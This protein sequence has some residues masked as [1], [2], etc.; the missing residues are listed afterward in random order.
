MIRSKYA[1]T[2][3]A[4]RRPRSMTGSAILVAAESS[5]AHPAGPCSRQVV[6]SIRAGI[7]MMVSELRVSWLPQP[8]LAAEVLQAATR[9]TE[10]QTLTVNRRPCCGSGRCATRRV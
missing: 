1:A 9:A 7:W 8:A 5:R 4:V 3:A 6:R 10:A 2:P